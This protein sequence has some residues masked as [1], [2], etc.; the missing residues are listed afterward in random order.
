MSDEQVLEEK[1]LDGVEA[2]ALNAAVQVNNSAAALVVLVADDGSLA[3]AYRVVRG[4]TND[5]LTTLLC[6]ADC[7]MQKIIGV[8]GGPKID[9]GMR[10]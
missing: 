2:L 10:H 9:D 6:G 1:S 4:D 7:F 8:T 5:R 3:F